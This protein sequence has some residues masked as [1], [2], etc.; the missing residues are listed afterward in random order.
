MVDV[1]GSGGLETEPLPTTS[2]T[3]VQRL[4]ADGDGLQLEVS[5]AEEGTSANKLSGG[6]ILGGEVAFINGVE[7]VEE[8]EVGAGNLYI[9]EVVHGHASLRESS[10]Q[11]IEHELD[12]ILDLSGWLTGLGVQ[13]DAAGQIEGVS[14]KNAVAERGLDDLIRG[15]E[16]LAGRTGL[17]VALRSH[18]IRDADSAGHGRAVRRD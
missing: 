2:Q 7:F 3:S 10:F 17:V 8:G 4:A 14:S 11:A 13:A 5:A 18:G 12:F 16:N 9:D 15:V 6:V 1:A